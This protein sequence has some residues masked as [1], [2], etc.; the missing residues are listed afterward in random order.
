MIAEIKQTAADLLQ[1]LEAFNEHSFN[2]VPFEG[3]WTAGQVA[4]HPGN[5][6]L[7]PRCPL[8]RAAS[9][10][11]RGNPSRRRQ[12]WAMVAALSGVI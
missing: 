3:S 11:A 9:S 6:H 8:I 2:Q 1:A 4:E 5:A 10:M 12:I 7:V